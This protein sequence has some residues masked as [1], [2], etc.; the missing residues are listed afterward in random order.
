MGIFRRN[1]GWSRG[2]TIPPRGFGLLHQVSQFE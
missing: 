2:I 1:P